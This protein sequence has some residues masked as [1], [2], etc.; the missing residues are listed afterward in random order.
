MRLRGLRVQRQRYGSTGCFCL[1]GQKVRGLYE[2]Q[3]E[4]AGILS[5]LV[6][7][8]GW[9]HISWGCPR[10]VKMPDAKYYEASQIANDACLKGPE[11]STTGSWSRCAFLLMLFFTPITVSSALYRQASLRSGQ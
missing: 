8:V 2:A 10:S 3:F 1:D 5:E 9:T 4:A 11:E 7:R 6:L